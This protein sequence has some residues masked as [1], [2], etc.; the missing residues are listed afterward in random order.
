[1]TR[2]TLLLMFCL[3]V[4]QGSAQVCGWTLLSQTGSPGTPRNLPGLVYDDSASRVI[5]FGGGTQLNLPSETWAWDGT[6]WSQLTTSNDPPLRNDHAMASR[7]GKTNQK[8][9]LFGGVDASGTRSD[10][11]TFDGSDWTQH[12]VVGP[13]GL[14]RGGLVFHEAAGRFIHFGGLDNFCFS[15]TYEWDGNQWNALFAPGP[16]P[17][18]GHAMAYDPIRQEIVLY[19]GYGNCEVFQQGRH[20]NDTWVFDGANWTRRPVTGP[21]ALHGTPAMAFDPTRGTVVLHGGL[22][23]NNSPSDETWEWNGSLW[24][25]VNESNPISRSQTDMVFDAANSKL[26]FFGGGNSELRWMNWNV[27]PSIDPVGG[28]ATADYPCPLSLGIS[29]TGSGTLSFQWYKDNTPLSNGGS[30]SG[31]QSATLTINPTSS[32]TGGAYHCDVTDSCTTTTSNTILVNSRCVAD[33]NGNGVADPGDFT[34]W[35]NAF[36]T[37]D[38]AAEQNCDGVLTPTDFTAWIA[39]YNAGC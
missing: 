9:L 38:S 23:P 7:P 3:C 25:L 37:N 39:N 36:N 35:I 28:S 6:T 27:G 20:L 11:W 13:P 16:D 22:Y 8:I 29:A 14:H 15:D 32:L 19:G 17:R 12:A 33:V 10:T 21:P 1:M 31:A 34:A 2:L 18:Y 24:S 5:L 26:L 4:C 30:I